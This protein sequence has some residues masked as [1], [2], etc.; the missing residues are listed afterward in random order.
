MT[1]NALAIAATG[2]K[3]QQTNLDVIANNIANINTTGFKRARAE[4]TD[5]MY[6]TIQ[7]HGIAR[8][9]GLEVIPEGAKLGIGVKLAAIRDVHVQGV[10][11]Q[12]GNPFDI[13]INGEGWFQVAAA[14]GSTIY[15]RAGAFNLND[16]GQLVTLGGNLVQ[17]EITVPVEATKVTVTQQGQVY[18]YIDDVTAPVELGQL[19]LS[20]FANEAGL[21][22]LGNNLFAETEA[23]GT[24]TQGTPGSTDFGT[25]SQGYL[26]ASN[27]D[28][29]REIADMISAQR[30]YEMNSKVIQAADEM[31]SVVTKG[32]R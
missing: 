18:A 16:Q 22:P 30:A 11:N 5:I 19:T 20:R 23:S 32:I 27:V 12:T 7:S 15:T 9:A 21:E 26:E 8:Q 31:S 29:M 28:P 1:I 14:D 13:A 25:L 24:A 2:M 10:L 4:F 6:E 3:A 17:P